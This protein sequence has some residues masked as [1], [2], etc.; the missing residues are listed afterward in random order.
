MAL[1][2]RVSP[3]ARH[4]AG[5]TTATPRCTKTEPTGRAR[6][7]ARFGS[8]PARLVRGRTN[9]AQVATPAYLDALPH[10]LGGAAAG[11]GLPDRVGQRLQVVGRGRQRRLLVHRKPDHVPAE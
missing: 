3:R 6:R 2:Y 9:D 4:Y 8:A 11:R 10:R 1:A 7:Q 5:T